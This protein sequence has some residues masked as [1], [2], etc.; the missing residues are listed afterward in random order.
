MSR[1]ELVYDADCP[2]V[3]A[4]RHRLREI[5]QRLGE[6]PVWK[7]WDRRSR[8][9]PE[10]IRKYGSPTVLVD[11][12]DVAGGSHSD[13]NACCRVYRS[14]PAGLSGVPP[15]DALFGALQ[16]GSGTARGGHRR[17]SWLAV[18][19]AIGVAMLP[20]VACPACWPVYAG[21]LGSIGL[22]WLMQTEY[23]LPMT[24]AFLV[25]AVGSLG[26][27]ARARHGYGPFTIGLA[28]AVALFFSKFHFVSE[29]AMF[30]SIGVLVGASVWN[31][32]PRR[33]KAAACPACL[34]VKV[35]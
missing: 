14:G 30:A 3:V 22:G 13:G 11:G 33:A 29:G 18:A 4:T 2:H 27:R 15:S 32:W 6:P 21:L 23:L 26:F 24:V 28:A 34:E 20:K 8:S 10:H 35:H 9:C 12:M 5:L 16:R 7:E 31:A 17:S 25:V 1:V 19:P